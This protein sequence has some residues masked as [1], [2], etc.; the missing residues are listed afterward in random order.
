MNFDINK[1][2]NSAVTL[3]KKNSPALLTACSVI[4][5]GSACVLTGVGTV[6]AMEKAK[7]M[8]RET[9]HIPSKMDYVKACWKCYIPAVATGNIS[10]GCEVGGEEVNSSRG[11]LLGAG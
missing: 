2:V 9:D 7:E 10:G 8:E 5:M 4:A 3:A 1:T 6:K 11:A